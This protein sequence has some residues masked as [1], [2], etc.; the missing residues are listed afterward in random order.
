[1]ASTP[2]TTL[3][4]A[5]VSVD[6]SLDHVHENGR[7]QLTGATPEAALFEV[8]P[9]PRHLTAPQAQLTHPTFRIE[10]NFFLEAPSHSLEKRG[11]AGT[12]GWWWYSLT[13]TNSRD[14]HPRKAP[15]W[16]GWLGRRGCTVPETQGAIASFPL[17]VVL[18]RGLSQATQPEPS[19]PL[20]G[21]LTRSKI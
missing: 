9:D 21:Q 17:T 4:G 11:W 12:E 7:V 10:A 5:G 13:T 2:E 16:L 19:A 14:V 18:T 20:S 8:G 15:N 3:G 1:M 6:L